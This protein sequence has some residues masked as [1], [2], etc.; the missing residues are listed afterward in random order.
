MADPA[1]QAFANVLGQSYTDTVNLLSRLQST[2]N[3]GLATDH[4]TKRASTLGSASLLFPDGTEVPTS[5]RVAKDTKAILTI[6]SKRYNVTF[7]GGGTYG[8]IWQSDTRD[9][10]KRVIPQPG[11]SFEELARNFLCEC[12]IQ[13]VLN[14]DPQF[15]VSTSKIMEMYKDH[16]IVASIGRTAKITV[17]GEPIFFIKMEYI[18]YVLGSIVESAKFTVK[19][20]RGILY[21]IAEYLEHFGRRYDFY[22][23]DLHVGNIMMSETGVKII[24]FGMS[25]MTY[26]G[27]TYGMPRD[28]AVLFGPKDMRGRSIPK[29]CY[30]LDLLILLTSL[31]E[32]VN[33]AE[34]L[35]FLNVL[36]TTPHDENVFDELKK[37]AGRDPVFWKT[38]W[39]ELD[40]LPKKIQVQIM[41]LGSISPTGLQMLMKGEYER[42]SVTGLKLSTVFPM[43]KTVKNVLGLK[44]TPESNVES[45]ISTIRTIGGKHTRRHK[46]RSKKTR[47]H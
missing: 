47:K 37:I 43:L 33:N 27:V 44:A 45:A 26:N 16:N 10:F 21:K 12:W 17:T 5:P 32:K 14:E 18:P 7:K 40:S 3:T 36:V 38:Y 41:E 2:F 23:C 22:H 9:T 39:W 15:G 31:I 28:D 29:M 6:G 1:V 30:S 19:Q 42:D 13:T 46:R 24:D 4:S 25:C 35:A 11:K 20:C 8:E 34:V